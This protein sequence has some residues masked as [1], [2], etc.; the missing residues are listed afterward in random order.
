MIG[1]LVD[2]D[3]HLLLLLN[4]S[5][6]AY[7]D[8]VM[9]SVTHTSS[10]IFIILALL[11]V[12]ARNNDHK[13]VLL[14]IAGIALTIIVADQFSS[15]LCKP[16]FHRLRPSHDPWFGDAVDIVGGYRSG[17]YGFISS[18]AA[19]TFGVAVF[20]SKLVKHRSLTFTLFFWAMLASY[21]RIYL[22]VH[23]PGD[24][25]C[26]ALWGVITGLAVYALYGYMCR[27]W[28]EKRSFASSRYTQS[29]YLIEDVYWLDATF[30]LT[31]IYIM[32]KACI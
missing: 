6:S 27:L 19:N 7:W 4:G 18:H 15:T 24:I 17:L 12:L 16:M 3:R 28:C 26:G 21:S 13:G 20:V 29:G 31:Y 10:W 22:G 2:I 1:Q 8:K 14:A 9:M 11:V 5:D 25:L 32:I 30:Y 23:Y